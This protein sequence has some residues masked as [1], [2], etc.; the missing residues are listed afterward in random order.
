MQS[1]EFSLANGSALIKQLGM[2]GLS[3]WIP[4]K[5]T[6]QIVLAVL[7]AWAPL[8]VLTAYNGTAVGDKVQVPFLVDLVQHARFLVALPCGIALGTIVN[9]RLRSVLNSF[10]KGRIVPTR[11]IAHFENAINRAVTGGAVSTCPA[12]S[13]VRRSSPSKRCSTACP[14]TNCCGP[15]S[16]RR[17][18][19]KR[20][21]NSWTTSSRNG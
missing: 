19:P 1:V 8:L 17:P 21:S 15:P 4:Q 20:C 5:L 16:P 18:I 14:A 3:R 11:D 7:I 6:H 12:R 2:F 10:L 9:P 13:R